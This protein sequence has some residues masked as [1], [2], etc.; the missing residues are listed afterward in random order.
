MSMLAK[1]ER[2]SALVTRMTEA[3]GADVVAGM[4]D[5]TI[6]ETDLRRSVVNCMRCRMVGPC[7]DWLEETGEGPAQAPEFCRNKAMMDRLSAL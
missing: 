3:T 6:S 2:H 1:I 4:T 5:G 7:E